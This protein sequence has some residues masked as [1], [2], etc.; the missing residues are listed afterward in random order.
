MDKKEARERIE[1]L[2]KEIWKHNYKYHVLD[3]SD[4]SDAA[5]DALKNELEGLEYKFPD[6]ITTDSPT[7]RVS[8]KPL[9]KFQKFHHSVPMLSFNDAFSKQEMLDW[10]NRNE[11]IVKNYDK[12]G[13]YCELKIDG[14]AIELVYKNGIL[15][16]G[17]TRGDGV[18]GEN[19]TQNLRTIASIPLKLFG[20]FPKQL[21]VRGEVYLETKEFKRINKE[22][23]K[24]REKT[25]A[26]PRNLAAGSIR[27]LDPK[28][29]AS[30]RLDSFA[31]AL[32]TDLGQKKHEDE[33]KILRELGFKINLYNK[34]C[35]DLNEVEK[36]RIYWEKKR[37]KL[38]Y[39]IDGIV[40]VASDNFAFKKLGAIGKAPR[41]AIAYKFSAKEATTIIKDVIWQ[42]G[43]T[44]VLTPVA[45]LKPVQIG[46]AT[47]TH[48]TLHNF[49]E[50][51]RLEVKIGDTVIV[52]RAGDVIPDI[53]K[54]LKDMRIGK[55]KEIKV[56][57]FCPACNS[58]VVKIG[59]EVAYKC[60]DKNC[61]AVLRERIY[62]FVSR[63]AFDIVGVGP[64][65]V[66]RFL[67]E[68]L[69]KDAGDLFFLE[70]EDMKHLERFAEKS[71]SNIIK[72]IQSR[73]EIKLERFLFGLGIPQV[74]E[75]TA[76]DLARHYNEL[77]KI[78]DSSLEELQRL[79]DIGPKVAESI[80]NW[81]KEKKSL[82]FLHKLKKAGIKIISPPRIDELRESR[83]ARK[84]KGKMFVLTGEL[85]NMT[86]EEAKEKI[87][88]LGGDISSSV[89]KNTDFV[90]IGFEPGS[91]FDKAK[92]LG[93]KIISE[94]EFAKLI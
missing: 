90:V 94:K 20:K 49:D 54:P 59:E 50:I 28:I 27:Q 82:E 47:I 89:S 74:G 65:I 56:P 37:G 57:H 40:V 44:G 33:H 62:H 55:E 35:K 17:A 79:Q 30:R 2:R 3:Q 22:L 39:E 38:D 60:S 32:I 51:K 45:V 68:G 87:R 43:R 53:V 31:Y 5:F 48:A 75:E 80:Y 72:S 16:T 23:E 18:V 73:K 46:G 11:K 26:N 36:L 93:V 9:D 12:G 86:R 13:Y 10:Q 76:I 81:F 21:I 88:A 84:L 85:E 63:K 83:R 66:D 70:E 24:K 78:K 64:K 52:G 58:K 69:I 91:K 1:K 25:Y 6:L 67:D 4:I 41:G 7:Q 61:G 42:I 8:G 29:T 14:L 92:K 15:K 77:G 71:A 34:F 19:V